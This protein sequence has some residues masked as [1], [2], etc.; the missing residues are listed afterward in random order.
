MA[1]FYQKLFYKSYILNINFLSSN[2]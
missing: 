2:K 1:K